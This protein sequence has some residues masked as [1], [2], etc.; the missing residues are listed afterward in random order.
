MLTIFSYENLKAKGK[1]WLVH[2][3]TRDHT[4]NGC[5]RVWIFF[6]AILPK[7]KRKRASRT[8]IKSA[9]LRTL[10]PQSSSLFLSH[11]G[12]YRASTYLTRHCRC[13]SAFLSSSP[14]FR[15]SWHS[16]C[17]PEGHWSA[18]L[19]GLENS[20]G[21][22]ALADGLPRPSLCENGGEESRD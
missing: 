17:N 2:F 19:T 21:G 7:A 22:A 1:C 20:V 3:T 16:P 18:A 11:L 9:S 13:Q 12:L 14:L 8:Q 5:T 10:S 6:H 15:E 4:N